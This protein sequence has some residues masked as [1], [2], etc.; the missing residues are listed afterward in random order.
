MVIQIIAQCRFWHGTL[1]HAL[2]LARGLARLGHEVALINVQSSV[3]F[4]SRQCTIYDGIRIVD[5]TPHQLSCVDLNIVVGLWDRHT[6]ECALHLSQ[7]KGR[8]ILAPTIYWPQNM[9]PDLTSQAE[10]LWY[11]SW[12]QAAWAKDYWHLAERVE[13]IRCVVDVDVFHTSTRK[14][15]KDPW[16]LGRHSRDVPEK[17][18]PDVAQLVE[19]LG[20]THNIVYHMLGAAETM[21]W[22]KDTRVMTYQEDAAA[23][24]EF[25]QQCDLWVYSHAPYWRETACIAML[26]AMACGL[27]VVVNNCGGMREYLQH[28]RTGFLCNNLDEFILNTSLLFD[29]PNLYYDVGNQARK[30]VERYHSLDSLV[31]RLQAVI[32][33]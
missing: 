28:G 6:I 2:M 25:L 18:A 11:V 12:D 17:F 27:P 32:H 20:Q 22:L 5:A 14:L 31:R 7:Q 9:L 4:E 21:S 10:A 29:M 23:P 30:F 24:P 33:P 15:T 13:I 1:Q 3:R 19:R 26:E 16:V 8:L